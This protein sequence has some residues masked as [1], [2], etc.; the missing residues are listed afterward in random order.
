MEKVMKVIMNDSAIEVYLDGDL[1]VGS[2]IQEG[3]LV[4]IDVVKAILHCADY[5]YKVIL[6]G[7]ETKYV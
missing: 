1:S 2:K 4:P 7:G 6:I 3:G 5:G